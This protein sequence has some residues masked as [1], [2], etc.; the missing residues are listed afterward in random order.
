M[1]LRKQQNLN[2][3]NGSDA[4]GIL[5]DKAMNDGHHEL[6]SERRRRITESDYFGLIARRQEQAFEVVQE[7]HNDIRQLR[8]KLDDLEKRV[9]ENK[10]DTDMLTASAL[11]LAELAKGMSWAKISYRIVIGVGAI[12]A[13]IIAI[14]TTV[15]F[16]RR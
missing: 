15:D 10:K 11:E 2:D 5:R 1:R 16:L 3:S 4:A 8:K 7:L 6:Q 9:A 12:G 13:A 14:L